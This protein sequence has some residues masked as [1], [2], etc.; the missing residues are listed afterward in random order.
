MLKN[1]MC[2]NLLLSITLATISDSALAADFYVNPTGSDRNN[3]TSFDSPMQTIQSAIDKA[4]PGDTINLAPGRYMQDFITKTDGTQDKPITITGSTDAVIKGG[5]KPR[6]VEVNHDFIVLNGFTIDGLWGSANS[7]KGYR[8]KLIYVQ[9]K[10]NKSGVENLKIVNMHIE[11]A[12][13]ECVRLRYLAK[14]NEIAFNTI[15]KCGVKDFKFGGMK[16]KNGEGIYIG[17]A[18]EQTGDGKNPTSDLDQSSNNWIHDNDI[19]TQGNECVDIKEG[20]TQNIIENNSCTGQLD[21]NSAG[22]DSRGNNNIFRYNEVFG[23]R[24]AGVRLGGD[25]PS[26]G[27]NNQV[28][29][30]NIYN[31]AAGGI[32]IQAEN[33]Q[34]ICGNTMNNNLK[35]DSVGSFGSRFSPTDDCTFIKQ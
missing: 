2:F 10:G 35:G 7:A 15:E 25:T 14:N 26:D 29:G 34:Q 16:K 8:D 24:G 31:N 28:D 33:Q 13:G 6:V 4:Q 22:L 32:K 20:S 1:W 19:N 5:G 21:P 3:G 9:G 17:T 11:N 18:P 12:G 23:N 27:S 30:N